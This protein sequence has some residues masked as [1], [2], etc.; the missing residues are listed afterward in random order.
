MKFN[1]K[2]II[3]V[4]CAAAVGLMA[5]TGCGGGSENQTVD[6][7]LSGTYA[8]VGKDIQNTYMQKV[9]EG[10]ETACSENGVEAVYR[11]PDVNTSEKQIEIINS[12]VE[13][14]V[15]G[16]AVAAN[17][18]D[19]LSPALQN[20]MNSGVEVISVDSAVK[21]EDRR[22]HIQQADPQKIGS[23]L[24]QTAYDMAGG[25]GGIAILSSTNQATNQNLWIEYMRKEVADNAEK[26]ADM[27]IVYV[28]YGDDDMTKSITETQSILQ[29]PEV[30][31]IIAPTAVGIVAAAKVLSENESEIKLTGLGMP[32]QIAPYIEDGT[33]EKAYLWNPSDI[34]YLAGYTMNALAN[35]EITGA[36]GD[37][38]SAGKLGSR[39]ITTDASDGSE[40]MLGDLLEFDKTNIEQWKD[41]Y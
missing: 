8:F 33:C 12:L 26:Y 2:K 1:M 27:P 10:F 31:V 32:S 40:V 36:A 3:S 4:S 30:K 38:F 24:M 39:T 28:A 7:D 25:H 18:E 9:Y 37:S 19:A 34:G 29:N 22:T 13:Q 16:I 11:A 17:D 23:V 15:S 21:K 14:K 41:M 5:L 35:G 6:E 20:A